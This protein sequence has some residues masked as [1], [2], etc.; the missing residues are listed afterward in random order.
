[1]NRGTIGTVLKLG[2]LSLIAGLVMAQFGLK[3][4]EV[5]V[6]AGAIARDAADRA[7]DALRWAWGYILAGAVVVVPVWLAVHLWRR[8]KR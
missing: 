4:G 1:M 3:P 2:L 5:F 7:V 6:N 8:A